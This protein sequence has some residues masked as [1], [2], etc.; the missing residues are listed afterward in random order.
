MSDNKGKVVDKKPVVV[1]NNS[2]D[3]EGMSGRE[4]LYIVLIIIVI[5]TALYFLHP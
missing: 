4:W 3:T 2:E 5:L 1:D